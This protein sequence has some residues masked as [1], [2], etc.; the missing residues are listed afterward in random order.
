[1]LWCLAN[2]WNQFALL[3]CKMKEVHVALLIKKCWK[4]TTDVPPVG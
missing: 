4:E 1:M 3:N 2:E